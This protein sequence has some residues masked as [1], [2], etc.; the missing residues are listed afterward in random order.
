MLTYYENEDAIVTI[1][2]AGRTALA[3]EQRDI[4]HDQQRA[5]I[6]MWAIVGSVVTIAALVI[7]HLLG[8][9]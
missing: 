2:D 3:A 5:E 7:T 1:S 4:H 6:V 8:K 9:S